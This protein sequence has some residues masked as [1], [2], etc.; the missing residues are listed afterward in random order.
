MIRIRTAEDVLTAPLSGDQFFALLEVAGFNPKTGE[1][2]LI[3]PDAGDGQRCLSGVGVVED[4]KAAVAVKAAHVVR[5][6]QI[7]ARL[8]MADLGAEL[9]D[10]TM[11]QKR[12]K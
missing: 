10:I 4:I 8:D 11:D 7:N 1:L 6:M 2:R 12:H 5:V 9:A 3:I